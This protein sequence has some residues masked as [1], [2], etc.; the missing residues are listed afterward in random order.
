MQE[1][2]SPQSQTLKTKRRDCIREAFELKQVSSV[3]LDI[4][5][6][7]VFKSTKKHYKSS[8]EKWIKFTETHSIDLFKPEPQEL[9]LFLTK[10]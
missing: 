8:L 4:M 3:S 1:E 10:I 9:I 5:L 7:S 2:E 6:V